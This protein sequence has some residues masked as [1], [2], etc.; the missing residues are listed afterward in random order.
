MALM[1]MS[2]L[3]IDPRSRHGKLICSQMLEFPRAVIDLSQDIIKEMID[4]HILFSDIPRH[5]KGQM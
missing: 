3:L 5:P 1:M 4:M 2:S